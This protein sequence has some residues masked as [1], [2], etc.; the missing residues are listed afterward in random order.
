MDA[1]ELPCGSFVEDRHFGRGTR[2]RAAKAPAP[3]D[4]HVESFEEARIHRVPLQGLGLTGVAVV[5]NSN[6]A[7]KAA[8]CHWTESRHAGGFH[9]RKRLQSL[10]YGRV[11]IQHSVAAVSAG[12]RLDGEE[13]QILAI[14]TGVKAAQVAECSRQQPGS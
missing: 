1:E 12:R 4:R 5:R 8:R 2:I 7:S 10:Q 13:E 9:A 3:H 14:E 11:E 6:S